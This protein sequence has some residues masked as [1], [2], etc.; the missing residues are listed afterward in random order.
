M[1]SRPLK[2]QRPPPRSECTLCWT[3]LSHSFATPL[4]RL[5]PARVQRRLAPL[6]NRPAGA[7][8]GGRGLQFT[9]QF[10]AAAAGYFT[11]TWNHRPVLIA[12]ASASGAG[13]AMVW[14][15]LTRRLNPD[16]EPRWHGPPPSG[17][18][19]A[20]LHLENYLALPPVLRRKLDAFATRLA[21]G[22]LNEGIAVASG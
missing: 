18:W 3:Q 8:P 17:P 20:L 19:F 11:L 2:S 12:A 5:L 4:P 14:E 7:V 6:L 10:P 21:L 9:L 15:T 22:F 13:G 16:S 1:K